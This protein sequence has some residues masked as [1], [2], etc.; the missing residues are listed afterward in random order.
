MRT[1]QHE[2]VPDPFVQKY[3]F[4]NGGH[5][6]NYY[7][8]GEK[9]QIRII[10]NNDIELNSRPQFA[11]PADF[12]KVQMLIQGEGNLRN[13]LTKHEKTSFRVKNSNN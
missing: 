7:F 11:S 10:N 12:N 4:R 9:S 1:Y 13:E 2:Q 3:V 6:G 5:P 8:K